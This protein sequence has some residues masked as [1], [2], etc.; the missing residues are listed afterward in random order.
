GKTIASGSGDKTV[1]LWRTDGT[2]LKTIDGHEDAI[3]GV[4]FSPDGKM[5]ASASSDNTVKLWRTDGI[6]I[7]TFTGHKAKMNDIVFSLDGKTL[8]YA[9]EDKTVKLW[10][11]NNINNLDYWLRLGCKRLRVY[12]QNPNNGM[13]LN[14]SNRYL[15]DDVK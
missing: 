6:L 15:C 8:A 5:I 11:L 12:L 7:T 2:L 1:K 9:S 13:N 14:N 4:A 10:S 3:W